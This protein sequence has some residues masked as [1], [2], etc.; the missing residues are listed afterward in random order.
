MDE[1]SFGTVDPRGPDAQVA[2]RRYLS[3]VS[4][5]LV[6]GVVSSEAADEVDDFMPPGGGFVLGRHGGVVIGCGG[7]RPLDPEVGE[8]KRMWIE[9]GSRGRGL[10]SRLLRSLEDLARDRKY[11][12]VRLDTNKVLVQAIH[13]YE[14]RGY[15][16]ID[17]YNDNPDATHFY[18]KWLTDALPDRRR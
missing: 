17:R 16:Q 9:A 8:I 13:L 14:T 18:E 5:S 7:V 3:E 4:V 15:R 11:E 2:L 10:G 1:V 6:H 12:R